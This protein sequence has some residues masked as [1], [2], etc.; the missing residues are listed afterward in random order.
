M[1]FD[2]GCR[3]RGG[4]PRHPAAGIVASRALA[5]RTQR[6]PIA[7]PI[8]GSKPSAMP[9]FIPPQLATLRSKVP[10]GDQWL[11]EIKYDGYRLQVRLEKGKVT[12]RNPHRARLDQALLGD[13]GRV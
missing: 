5:K 3:Y 4:V 7:K 6:R 10:P 11:H 9:G 1:Q 2:R 8:E 13:R 12:I